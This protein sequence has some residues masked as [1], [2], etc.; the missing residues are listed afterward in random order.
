MISEQDLSGIRCC[1]HDDPI[2]TDTLIVGSETSIFTDNLL[3]ICI[4]SYCNVCAACGLD[5][6]G[7]RCF[8]NM[9]DIMY[10]LIHSSVND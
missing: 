2:A 4:M 8:T 5:L 3:K 6:L 10:R 9:Y 1:L 7:M